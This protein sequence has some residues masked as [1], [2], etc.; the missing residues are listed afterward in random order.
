MKT[1]RPIL[2]TSL[3]VLFACLGLGRFGFGMVLPSMEQNLQ[4]ST[5]L[6]GIIG[7][8]NFLGYLAG[9]FFVSFLY[10]RFQT[11]S[12]IATM[13]FLQAVCM[14]AMTFSSHYEL[15]AFFYALSGFFSAVSNIAIMVYVAHIVP[16]NQRGKALGFIITGFGYAI[17]FAGFYVPYIEQYTAKYAWQTSW[18]SFAILTLI[19]AIITKYTLTYQD[20]HQQDHEE[21]FNLQ[22]T[23][24]QP[25]FWKI[26]WVYLVFGLTYVIYVTYFVYAVMD[27]YTL[28]IN[29]SGNFWAILGFM[30]LISGPILGSI[31]DKI[32]A[33]KTLI[34]V[35]TTLSISHMILAFDV[36]SSWLLISV[37]FF[38]LTAWSI[39]PLITLLTSI[40]FG[41][42]KTAQVFSM[43]TIIFA[44]GQAIAPV[45]A[46]YM[47]D[48][49]GTFNTVFFICMLLCLSAALSAF[50][51]SKHKQPT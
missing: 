18:N 32:G 34:I 47:Y 39:P 1:H 50:I 26:A 19:I 42:H 5:T 33:Y 23:L 8:A 15:V 20:K 6:S 24:K 37:I 25:A 45:I 30:S 13:L 27:K 29:K 7:T 44:T 4:I 51:F 36:P 9:I 16:E 40:H 38:G 46:G 11:A 35:Y 28:D 31:A 43:I 14:S 49:Q 12:L 2:L 22:K 48:I 21:P 3:L 41:K 17:I 10:K